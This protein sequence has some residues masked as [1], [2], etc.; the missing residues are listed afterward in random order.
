MFSNYHRLPQLLV[1]LIVGS[2]CFTGLFLVGIGESLIMHLRKCV[3]YFFNILLLFKMFLGT[4][5]HKLLVL[6]IYPQC[7][8]SLHTKV[9]LNFTI[10]VNSLLCRITNK[11]KN[12]CCKKNLDKILI[13]PKPCFIDDIQLNKFFHEGYFR[14]SFQ[15]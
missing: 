15:Y 2:L 14:R 10:L 7:F 1:T 12:N 9:T 8:F 13:S 3:F 6:H 5:V 11:I 4:W